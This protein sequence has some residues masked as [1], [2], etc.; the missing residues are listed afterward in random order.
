MAKQSKTAI[1]YMDTGLGKKN[2]KFLKPRSL[3]QANQ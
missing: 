2:F 3:E 1:Y